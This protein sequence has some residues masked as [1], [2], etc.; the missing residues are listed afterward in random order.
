MNEV[1]VLTFDI[2]P[3]RK[4]EPTTSLNIQKAIFSKA[5]ISI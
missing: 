2:N 4:S 1:K 5:D 3:C